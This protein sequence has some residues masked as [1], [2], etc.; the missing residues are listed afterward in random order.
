MKAR[1]KP[2]TQVYDYFNLVAQAFA[3]I[4]KK[5]YYFSEVLLQMENIGVQSL[6]I[7][8]LTSTFVGMILAYQ[9][10]FAMAVFGAK[11]YIGTL[12]S[13]SLVRELGPVL[14]SVVVA[15]R[16]GAGTAAELGSMLVTEQIDAMR[17]MGTDPIKKLVTTRLIAG[18]IMI[19]FLVI[20]ADLMGILGG[21]FIASSAFGLAP[22]F[23]KKTVIQALVVEDLAM[24]LLKGVFFSILII[25]MGCYAGL[26]VEGGTTGVGHATTR[27]V[28]LSIV[29]ILIT[30]YF[31]TVLLL[32]LLPGLAF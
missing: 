18:M 26:N 8:L 6:P 13:L 9:A 29:F 28:V 22:S 7:V 3:G 5:P 24:T 23:Y 25:T 31:L 20:I 21:G 11:M 16:I 1:N 30:D 27:A 4:V 19:P 12:I 15:G 10:G 2:L 32:K 14:A 17:A